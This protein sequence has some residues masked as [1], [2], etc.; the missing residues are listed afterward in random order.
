M[1]REMERP[2][3]PAKPQ[4][5]REAT[6]IRCDRSEGAAIIA[7]PLPGTSLAA[8]LTAHV[9]RDGE[10]VLLVLKPSLWLIFFQSMRFVA[11]VVLGYLVARAF[12]DRMPPVNRVVFFNA[13]V[14]L[15]AGRLM[16]ATLVWMGRLYVLTDRRV[17]RLS[18]VFNI[19]IRD[20]PL[21]KVESTGITFNV[22]ERL[23]AVGSIEIHPKPSPDACLPDVWRT[24][25]RPADVQQQL[26]AAIRRAQN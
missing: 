19:D 13:A 16:W 22:T 23:C 7:E 15:V 21:R 11:A 10:I 14:F 26:E 4:P 12:A 3:R 5:K 20:C 25:P 9:L 8:L 6:A 17:I 18:G 1:I 24:V 2:T